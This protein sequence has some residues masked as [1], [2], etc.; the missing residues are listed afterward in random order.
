MEVKRALNDDMATSGHVVDRD[1]ICGRLQNDA[2]R[3]LA[4][5]SAVLF[6]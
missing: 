1:Q 6:M 2:K 3:P 5:P 4:D